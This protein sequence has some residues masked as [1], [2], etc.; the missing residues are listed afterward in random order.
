MNQNNSPQYVLLDIMKIWAATNKHEDFIET[1]FFPESDNYGLS[2]SISKIEQDLCYVFI[3]DFNTKEYLYVTPSMT[4]C[5]AIDKLMELTKYC[6]K[7]FDMQ[8]VA[9][10][11]GLIKI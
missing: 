9:N 8:K 7:D 5:E 6:Q 11:K 4:R 10:A 2:L 3:V 1:Y